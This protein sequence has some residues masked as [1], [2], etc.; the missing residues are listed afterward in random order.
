M[1]KPSEPPK[2]A[3]PDR[4]KFDFSRWNF[5][6]LTLDAAAAALAGLSEQLFNSAEWRQHFKA[7]LPELRQ[8]ALDVFKEHSREL[9][10]QK[11]A[12]AEDFDRRIASARQRSDAFRKAAESAAAPPVVQPTPEAFHL[13]VKVVDKD[14]THLGLPGLLV[15]VLAPQNK[16][17][18]LVVS[19]TDRDGNA[20][21]TVPPETAKPLDKRD[22]VLEVLDAAG[23]ALVRL[24]DAVCVRLGQTEAKVVTIDKSPATK[25]HRSAALEFRAA[26]EAQ[27]RNHAG[28]VEALARERQALL[29]GL[30]LRLRD[31]DEIIAELEKSEPARPASEPTPG[32]APPPQP[33]ESKKTA[34]RS[35]GKQP[36]NK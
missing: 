23:K 2:F 3:Q 21:L 30:D 24:P 13:A 27:A 26:R 4:S 8:G 10:E 14:D 1:H 15:Q 22:T 17:T 28:R 5:D 20:V 29:D 32:Q 34:R 7:T 9:R 12:A 33:E 16:K 25:E 11:A 35:S 36:K 18:P 19:V 6:G 31:N